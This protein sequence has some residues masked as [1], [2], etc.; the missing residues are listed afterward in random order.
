MDA[1]WFDFF[2]NLYIHIGVPCWVELAEND[3]SKEAYLPG[4]IS[5]VS[6]NRVKVTYSMGK[7]GP[8]EVDAWKVCQQNDYTLIPDGLDDMVDM[9]NLND[10]E[11]LYNI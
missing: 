6:G 11:L 2:H 10:A 1:Y 3:P 5:S 9:E 7:S 4:Q 8:P